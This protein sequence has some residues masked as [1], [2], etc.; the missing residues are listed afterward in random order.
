MTS[1]ERLSEANLVE[2]GA[3]KAH[4]SEADEDAALVHAIEE[5][6]KSEKV[7]KQEILDILQTPDGDR[8]QSI[9]CA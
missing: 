4:S 5:G 8:V 3:K 6:L 9:F 7:S 2:S 1:R